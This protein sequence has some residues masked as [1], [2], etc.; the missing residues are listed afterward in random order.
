MAP[1]TE[2][3]LELLEISGPALG[4]AAG[5]MRDRVRDRALRHR[6]QPLLDVAVSGAVTRRLGEV[7]IWD[8]TASVVDIAP[9][10]AVS[11][12]AWGLEMLPEP[13]PLVSAYED[14]DLLV[15]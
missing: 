5:K 8:R 12:A 14:H 15:V 6:S 7:R 4:A 3:G 10:V 1:L 11:N 9:L 13:E 2:A